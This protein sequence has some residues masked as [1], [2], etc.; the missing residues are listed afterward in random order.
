MRKMAKLLQIILGLCKEIFRVK[1]NPSLS[2][3][4]K[5]VIDAARKSLK[6]DFKHNKLGVTTFSFSD[7]EKKEMVEDAKLA[8]ASLYKKNRGKEKEVRSITKDQIVVGILTWT[9]GFFMGLG[10]FLIYPLL[11]R[12]LMLVGVICLVI[13]LCLIV[14]KRKKELTR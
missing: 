5:I 11:D 12:Y 7:E 8:Q 6:E 2:D 9:S 10:F 4:A 3:Q 14:R 1:K 13:V